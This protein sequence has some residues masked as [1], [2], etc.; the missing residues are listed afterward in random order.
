MTGGTARRHGEGGFTLI[1]TV[2]ALAIMMIIL[3][4]LFDAI[5]TLIA[6]SRSQRERAADN[7]TMVR[8]AETVKAAAYDPSCSKYNPDALPRVQ[9]VCAPGPTLTYPLQLVTITILTLAGAQGPS[10]VVVKAS[11]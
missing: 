9:V 1:E 7:Q 5:F 11:R 4:T 2:V 8:V 6:T 3:P 10:V